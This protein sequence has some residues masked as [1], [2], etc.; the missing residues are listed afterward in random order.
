MFGGYSDPPYSSKGVRKLSDNCFPLPWREGIK[1]RGDIIYWNDHYS[2]SPQPSP[3]HARGGSSSRERE[4]LG[5]LQRI[6]LK[7]D[8]E[9]EKLFN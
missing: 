3:V 8:H 1:G 4:F 6:I 5:G 2:P 7:S 9:V